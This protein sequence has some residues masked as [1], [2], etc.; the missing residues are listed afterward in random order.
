VTT[1][2]RGVL[3]ALAGVFLPRAAHAQD[4]PEWLRAQGPFGYYVCDIHE[5]REHGSRSE[6]MWCDGCL[7]D[8]LRS[9]A[10]PMRFEES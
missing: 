3:A 5:K 2:R 6:L 8:A 7:R 1:G 10:G 4:L 9:L